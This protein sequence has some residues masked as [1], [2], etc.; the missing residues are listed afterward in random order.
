MKPMRIIHIT[1]LHFWTIVL[2]PFRLL[3][4][5]VLGNLNLI[6]RRAKHIRTERASSFIALMHELR[7][8]ALL[9]GGDL[10]CTALPSE[11][12]QASNFVRA[13]SSIGF[14]IILVPG[15]HDV[16]T[17]ESVRK[18]TFYSFFGDICPNSSQPHKTLLNETIPVVTVPTVRPN[19][20]TSRGYVSREQIRLTKRMLGDIEAETILVMAHYP[21]FD[22]P[23]A[24][25]C[26]FT[27]R[28]LGADAL[29]SALGTLNKRILYLAGH[30]H[31]FS[32][33]NDPNYPLVE[34][35]T[36]NALFYDKPAQPGGFTEIRLENGKT[37]IIPWQFGGTWERMTK[38]N[39]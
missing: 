2:N 30:V 39:R 31:V 35:V 11:F 32:R 16:Y 34:Q 37:E 14:P 36:S 9:I 22:Y 10:T 6:F 15:N 20:L 3:N 13:L 5:R 17:F 7:P 26:G 19:L 38:V 28:L 12:I 4:K 18:E 1:D 29:R 21:L 23:E 24:Y 27:R 33:A 8:D 25:R